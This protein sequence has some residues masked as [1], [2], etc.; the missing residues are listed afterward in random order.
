MERQ[1][2][3]RQRN[4]ETEKCRDRN[5]EMWRDGDRRQR[6]IFLSNWHSV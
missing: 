3:E 1:R 4:G 6:A 5:M 2:K